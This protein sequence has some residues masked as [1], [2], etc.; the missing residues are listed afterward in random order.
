M[1][2]G[3]GNKKRFQYCVD[4]S[5]QEILYLRALQ[6]HSGRNF[7]DPTLQDNALIPND[8]FE[9]IYH[10]GCAINLHSI[11]NSGLTPGGQTLNNRQT[12]FFTSVKEYRDPDKIDL[13]A[14]RLAWYHQK[15]WKK[16]QNMVY[17]VDIR[18][19]QKKGLK[20][21]QTRSNATIL[22]D[23]LPAYC[24]PK[25]IM[26]G[27]GEITYERVYAS[28][29]LPPKISFE[30]NWR[31]ELGSEVAGGSEDSQQTQPR[32]KNPIVRTGR[33]VF[34][35]ATIRFEC[36]GN[37][38]TCLAWRRKHQCKN[39]ETC[40]QLCAS[41]CW[42]FRSRQRRRR[43]RRRRSS[44]NRETR[45][46]WTIHR[47]VHTARGNRHWLQSVWIATCSCETSRKLPCS[48]SKKIDGIHDRFQR[49]P[50]YRDS[51]LKIGWTEE[52]C[53][54]MDELAQKDQ[55]YCPS[56]EEYEGYRKNW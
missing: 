29:R 15:T 30:D 33:P 2:G 13:E 52:K 41:V 26:M 54:A 21:Y 51:Q 39:R 34:G 47:F 11:T 38:Q 35:R 31:K 32:T 22:H 4:A 24:I 10:I 8:F 1:A 9:Y 16:H 44:K 49:D 25:A 27:T 5:G 37:R 42:T 14:P 36:S 53:I 45:W 46:K 3:G 17:W 18:L 6:G 50:V 20:F 23:T 40:F 12:V 28:P 7:I 43:K 19:A 56:S 55:S 48:R